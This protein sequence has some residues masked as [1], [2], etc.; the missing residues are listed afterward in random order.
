MRQKE[1]RR[2]GKVQPEFGN[3]EIITRLETRFLA[4]G[5]YVFEDQLDVKGMVTA[6]VITCSAWLLEMYEL[7]AGEL[8]FSRGQTDVYPATKCF[9]VFYPP[10]TISQPC[11]RKVKGRVI[12]MAAAKPLPGIPS[13]PTIFEMNSVMLPLGAGQ[14]SEILKAGC[15]RQSIEVNPKASSLSVRAKRLVDKTRAMDPSIAR[16]A[17]RLGVTHEHLSRQFRRD[18]GM[19][20]RD[21]LHQ[22]RLADVPLQLARGEAIADVSQEVGYGDLSRFYKQFRKNTRTSPALCRKMVAPRRA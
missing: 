7:K 20:P 9:G 10:F 17:A 3:Q 18:Y 19:S 8:F 4:D 13:V 16:I 12:G 11:L 5:T 22:L 21:Y 2:S 6:K 15:N 14:V 1:A